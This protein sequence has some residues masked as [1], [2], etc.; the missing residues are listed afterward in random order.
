LI[1]TFL[2][3]IEES[4]SMVGMENCDMTKWQ[5]NTYDEQ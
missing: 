4:N 1:E 3:G 5:I 2:S